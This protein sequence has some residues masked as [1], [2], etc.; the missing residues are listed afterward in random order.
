MKKT[1]E[2]VAMKAG[3]VTIG[4][5]VFLTIFKM[6]AGIVG[7]ST[8]MIADAM[9]T[10]SDLYTTVI[11]MIGV[12][13]ANKKADKEHPYG[14]ERFE[15][16]AA[17]LLS[18]V[19]VFTGGGIG[20]AGIQQILAHDY[21]E[22]VIPG[23]IALI[24]AVATLIIKTCMY[25]YKKNV[26]EKINSGAMM[27]DAWHHLSDALSSVGSFIGILG[28]RLGFPILDPIA[29]IVICLF[30]FKV[31]LDVFLDAIKKMT[32]R[33]C[34]EETEAVMRSIIMEQK[35]VIA[36]DLLRTR[37]FGNK[38]YV[39]LEVKVDGEHSLQSAHGISHKIHDAIEERFKNVKHCTVHVNPAGAESEG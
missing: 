23:I 17:I 18:V 6:I 36:I 7:N 11:V 9:H 35:S 25:F 37:L 16:V 13:L 22:P 32:D 39:E 28:A 20:W 4:V 29:A 26:A 12:K 14:H 24:A 1:N 27:A 31:A 34:D 30:I 2:Q 5:N 19:L 33:A 38:I 15:C 8:A 3:W 21:G 10:F